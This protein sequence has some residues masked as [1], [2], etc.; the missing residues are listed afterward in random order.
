MLASA[1]VN[2]GSRCFNSTATSLIEPHCLNLVIARR[3]YNSPG[4][5]ITDAWQAAITNDRL[6]KQGG[7]AKAIVPSNASVS[8]IDDIVPPCSTWWW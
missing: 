4:A 3:A 8:A 1:I 7:I 5:Q 2:R 6:G